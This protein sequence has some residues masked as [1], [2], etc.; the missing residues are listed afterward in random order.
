[1]D[2]G[3]V[4]TLI[5]AVTASIISIIHVIGFYWGRKELKNQ[6]IAARRQLSLA[7][8]HRFQV[9]R[10]FDKHFEETKQ[11]LSTVEENTNGNLT[12]ALDRIAHLEEIVAKALEAK[13]A[14]EKDE[15]M[16]EGTRANA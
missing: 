7:E 14:K 11:K 5:A 8:D 3:Q 16:V 6:V 2:G 1:M 9:A 4:A 15:I 10:K 12:K 13:E